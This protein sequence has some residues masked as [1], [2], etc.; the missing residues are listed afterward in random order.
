MSKTVKIWKAY[1][2]WRLGDKWVVQS[3][4]A[5]EQPTRYKV[6]MHNAFGYRTFISKDGVCLTRETAVKEALG[7]LRDSLKRTQE[8]I[9]DL[10]QSIAEVKGLL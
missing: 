9:V 4:D 1:T 2:D 3:F 7:W 6:K 10:E 5:I 8:K